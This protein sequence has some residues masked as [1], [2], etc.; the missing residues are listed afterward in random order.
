MATSK[1]PGIDFF[2]AK[3]AVEGRVSVRQLWYIKDL[4]P[5]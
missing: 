2:M 5:A 1:L 3:F 4:L